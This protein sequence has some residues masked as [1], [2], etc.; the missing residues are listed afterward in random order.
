MKQ[1]VGQ[2]DRVIRVVAGVALLAFAALSESELR[3]VGLIGVVPLLTGLLGFCPA[4][5]L[6]K[7]STACC[8]GKGE[9]GEGGCCGGGTCSSEEKPAEKPAGHCG[10]G[11]TH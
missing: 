1:N 4:Y 7:C 3:W 5:T 2:I 6:C 10:C 11:H 9:K 8:G